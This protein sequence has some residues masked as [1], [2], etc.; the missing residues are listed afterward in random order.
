MRFVCRP[1]AY[2]THVE[3]V[4]FLHHRVSLTCRIDDLD[5]SCWFIF[6]FMYLSNRS[7]YKKSDQSS[8]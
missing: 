1:S 4:L 3:D 6:V 8:I 5:L 2:W 7:E